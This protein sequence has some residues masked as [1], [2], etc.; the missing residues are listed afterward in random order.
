MTQKLHYHG[1]DDEVREGDRIEYRTFFLRRKKLGTVVC[2]PEKTALELAAEKKAPDDWLIRF[3]DGTD[4]GWMYHP[5]E[6]QP[7]GRLRLVSRGADY[8][9]VTSAEIEEQEAEIEAEFGWKGDLLGC[10]M[11]IAIAFAIIMLMAVVK[12][13]LPW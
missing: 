8:E 1:T 12:Y 13:G 6:L 2:I 11:L 4:F 10:L 5:E 7:P 3:D 9:R